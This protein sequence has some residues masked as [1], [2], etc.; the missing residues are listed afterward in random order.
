M[1]LKNYVFLYFKLTQKSF[2]M[3]KSIL[4]AVLLI[5]I[6][7]SSMAQKQRNI[8]FGSAIISTTAGLLTYDI[9]E[10]SALSTFNSSNASS[11]NQYQSYLNNSTVTPEVAL[12]MYNTQLH[13]NKSKYDKAVKA[14]VY[15]RSIMAGTGC[16]LAIIAL[17]IN[18]EGKLWVYQGSKSSMNVTQYGTQIGL[19]LNF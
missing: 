14:A 4:F 16:V 1:C 5:A 9:I 8:L 13:D 17:T 2:F 10:R 12:N 19:C 6:A 3:K 18:D 15:S 7:V 11:L